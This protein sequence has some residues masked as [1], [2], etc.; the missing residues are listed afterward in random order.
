[1]SWQYL[2]FDND[3]LQ[4]SD[5]ETLK[6]SVRF[7]AEAAG[8]SMSDIADAKRK[9]A[10]LELTVEALVRLLETKMSL[11]RQELAVMIQQID[12][13]D[14]VQDGRI[15]PD[16]TEHAP[17]CGFCARPLNRKR[18]SCIYC[19]KEVPK[20]AVEPPPPARLTG[21]RKCK[22]VLEEASSYITMQGLLCA[23][24]YAEMEP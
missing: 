15:G 12:L 20:K 13:A 8:D 22:R 11:D 9:I 2:F 16:R 10:Q 6:S 18:A 14:G 21:C 1:M 24:C 5:I 23:D 4:R 17:K 7:A 3:S 19:G